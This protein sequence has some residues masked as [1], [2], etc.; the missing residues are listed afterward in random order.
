MCLLNITFAGVGGHHSD[1]RMIRRQSRLAECLSNLAED[2]PWRGHGDP[3]LFIALNVFSTNLQ[4]NVHY[5]LFVLPW[6]VVDDSE[7]V[8]QVG[9]GTICA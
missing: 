2:F 8:K 6:G 3:A 1:F 7:A 9:H 4:G 5:L